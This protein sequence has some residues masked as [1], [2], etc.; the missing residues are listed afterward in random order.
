[1][2]EIATSPDLIVTTLSASSTNVAISNT[3]TL[4]ATVRNKGARS[5]APTILRWYLS[6]NS[7][8]DTNDTLVGTNAL[9]N[10]AAGMPVTISNRIT[11]PN[12]VGANTYYAC[13]DPVMGEYYTNDNCSS[14]VR[15][16]VSTHPPLP[17]SDFTT[18]AAA[19]NTKPTGLWSD[20]TTLWVADEADDQLYAYDLATKARVRA[21]DFPTLTEARNGNPKGLWSDGSTMWVVLYERLYAYSLASKT[22][23]PAQDFTTLVA[24]GNA[25]PTGLWSDGNTMWVV[26][27]R[28]IKLFAYDLANK[29]R[30]PAQ[31]FNTLSNAGNIRPNGLWSDGSTMWVADW[32]HDKLFAYDLASKARVPAKDFTLSNAKNSLYKGLWSDGST[33]WVADYQN[34]KLYAYD[35]RPLINTNSL[36]SVLTRLA[37][38]ISAPDY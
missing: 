9:G 34:A 21:Q 17:T 1:M 4:T 13:V 10:L 25:L 24:A 15:I 20:G 8:L 26:D 32:Y 29:A 28:E 31:D 37:Q 35:A 7:T 16:L 12:T 3:I 30:V 14:A 27:E 36:T 23:L 11:V 18:L 19:S 6:T 2:V 5:S 22:R 33:M 38:I